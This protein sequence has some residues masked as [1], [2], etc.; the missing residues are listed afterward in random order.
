MDPPTD[1]R[2]ILALWKGFLE[3]IKGVKDLHSGKDIVLV[4]Y[5]FF[6][7]YY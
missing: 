1:G 3:L 5:L 2:D 7:D 6:A 4:L